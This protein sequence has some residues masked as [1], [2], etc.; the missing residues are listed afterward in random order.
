MY[1][2]KPKYLDLVSLK[3][4]E[5]NKNIS[6]KV[7]IYV[8]LKEKYESKST[9]ILDRLDNTITLLSEKYNNLITKIQIENNIIKRFLYKLDH[10]TI[11]KNPI[12]I[13][14]DNNTPMYLFLNN[15]YNDNTNTNTNTN[16]NTSEIIK[17]IIK[18]FYNNS[19]LKFDTPYLYE[20]TLKYTFDNLCDY[21]D[22]NEYEYNIKDNN[23][24]CKLFLFDNI[25]KIK[26]DYKTFYL[27]ELEKTNNKNKTFNKQLK[28]IKTKI[29]NLVNENKTHI[30]NIKELRNNKIES[31]KELNKS[32][33][34]SYLAILSNNNNSL[35]SINEFFFFDT[36]EIY[37]LI[38]LIKNNKLKIVNYKLDMKNIEYIKNKYNSQYICDLQSSIKSYHNKPSYGDI[39]YKSNDIITQNQLFD[40]IK[41]YND[42]NT[43]TNT[44][45]PIIIKDLEGFRV[46]ENKTTALFSNFIKKQITIGKENINDIENEI[47][48][49]KA[50]LDYYLKKKANMNK[51]VELYNN[52]RY[53]KTKLDK[54]EKE[55]VKHIN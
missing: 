43:N 48:N 22:K 46:F 6:N 1:K 42:T 37:S 24:K 12:D 54:L 47:I 40:M 5:N 3:K 23:P 36:K 52:Y 2:I 31:Y 19:K 9:L 32:I 45:Y 53:Y 17:N 11:L 28:T 14:S 21:D 38:E 15:I 51:N 10:I 16:I 35:S 13:S 44:Y 39:N 49:V 34:N 26:L 8:G 33:Y 27:K 41:N 25:D 55:I 50:Q 29:S 4:N 30:E 18:T 20:S 7:N